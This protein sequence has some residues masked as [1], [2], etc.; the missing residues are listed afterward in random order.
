MPD[1][2]ER[3]K[4]IRKAVNLNQTDFGSRIGLK[5]ST[6][7]GYENGTR[8]PNESVNLSI[9]REFGI[10]YIYLVE[11]EGEMFVEGDD[12]A[13]TAIDRIMTG[14]NEFHK[15]LLKWVATSF[16]DE[17]LQLL[18]KKIDSFIEEFSGEKKEG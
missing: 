7:T 12:D 9:C 1:I 17:E 3:I 13:L 15:K 11:G 5:Q 2:S 14:E 8:I 4:A 6:I 10:S 18:E 16:S